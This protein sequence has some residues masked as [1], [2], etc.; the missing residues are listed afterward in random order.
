M[1]PHC[2][3]GLLRWGTW[4]L[5]GVLAT[6]AVLN[7]ASPSG[8]ERF[9]WGPVAL[10]LAGLYA[11]CSRAAQPPQPEAAI[12]PGEDRLPTDSHAPTKPAKGYRRTPAAAPEPTPGFAAVSVSGVT[13][14]GG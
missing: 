6:G 3:T 8:W 9:L 13:D 10:I 5:I 1:S 7:L 4:I 14:Y 2:P 11:C 12:P